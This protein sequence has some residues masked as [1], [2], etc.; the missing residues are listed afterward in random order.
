MADQDLTPVAEQPPQAP[1]VEE[2]WTPYAP[3]WTYPVAALVIR[4]LKLGDQIFDK[5]LHAYVPIDERKYNIADDATRK[6]PALLEREL[7]HFLEGQIHEFKKK[8]VEFKN[9]EFI[10]MFVQP[11][12]VIEGW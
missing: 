11:G 12:E 5:V 6:N 1:A 9:A 2:T 10:I 3:S 7:K 4:Q 8:F